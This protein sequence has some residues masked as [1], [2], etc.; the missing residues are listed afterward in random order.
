[1]SNI[2]KISVALTSEQVASLRDAVEGG[3]YATTSEAVREAIR[4]WQHKRELQQHD[5]L[6]LRQ[7][8]NEGL[9][10]GSAG[11]IDF[12]DIRREARSH[13]S[14]MKKAKRDAQ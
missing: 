11:E 8:W 1:M 14:K 7:L 5:I 6:R 13:L 2:E 12:E 4:D 10:S 9:A 3:D